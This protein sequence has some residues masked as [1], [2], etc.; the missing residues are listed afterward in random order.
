MLIISEQT[1]VFYTDCDINIFYYSNG[2]ETSGLFFLLYLWFN[3][4]TVYLR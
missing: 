3:F 4:S 1:C 2:S